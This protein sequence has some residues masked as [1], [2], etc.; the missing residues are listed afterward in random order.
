MLATSRLSLPG[1]IFQVSNVTGQNHDI[2]KMFLNLLRPTTLVN[3]DK[4]AEFQID[5]TFSVPGVGTVVSGTAVCGTIKVGESL[6]LGPDSTG[7]F[8]SVA[9]KGRWLT[10]L[11]GLSSL[12]SED[13]P[14]YL[15]WHCEPV[16]TAC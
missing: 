10:R 16:A 15:L 9:I 7:E 14:D 11:A 12:C 1:Q 13:P 6:L 5:D 8:Q 3:P 4:P 2:L